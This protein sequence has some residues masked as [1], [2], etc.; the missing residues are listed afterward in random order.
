[1]DRRESAALDRHITGNYGEDQF[2]KK[3]KP[4]ISTITGWLTVDQTAAHLQLNP[5]TILRWI[6]AGKL[7]A[8]KIGRSYRIAA[9][10]LDRYLNDR[11][12]SQ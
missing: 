9:T 1:M 5:M 6:K 12:V 11:K 3:R 4:P 10:E 2:P 7:P 8:S